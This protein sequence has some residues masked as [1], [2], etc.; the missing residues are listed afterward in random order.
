MGVPTGSA[1]ALAACLLAP[2]SCS[3]GEDERPG[4][5]DGARAAPAAAPIEQRAE[6]P[7]GPPRKRAVAGMYGLAVRSR[8]T[9]R[10]DPEDVVLLD[11]TFAFPGRARSQRLPEGA[12]P[13]R[14]HIR[15]AFGE[16]AWEWS[17]GAEGSTVLHGGERLAAL[18]DFELRRALFLWPDGLP[19]TPVEGGAEADLGPLGR[20]VATL[21]PDDPDAPPEALGLVAAD[22]VEHAALSDVTW[23]EC[24]GRRWPATFTVSE[25]GV[26]AWDEEVL[27]VDPA[28]RFLDAWFTPSD[29]REPRSSAAVQPIQRFQ[30]RPVAWKRLPLEAG[31]SLA[32]AVD[33]AEVLA[34]REAQVLE[35]TG[36]ALDATP[37]VEVD[38]AARPVAVLLE[39]AGDPP[40]PPPAWQRAPARPALSRYL[41]RLAALGPEDLSDLEGEAGEARD[42]GARAFVRSKPPDA[43]GHRAAE[44][45]LPLRQ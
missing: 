5:P 19:W 22:G 1:L 45:V 12:R 25:A 10:A 15:Y 11:T 41:P 24:D 21:A 34:R 9:S 3:R 40:R 43:D 4:T 38:G 16:E 28:V 6:D 31:L 29:R 17:P 8:L 30:L 33:R 35:R 13:A 2:A 18:G 42:A 14:R 27:S 7:E 39:L 37:K 44:V 26:V 23:R 32:E 20:V 36:H